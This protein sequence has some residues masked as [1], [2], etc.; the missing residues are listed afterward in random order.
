MKQKIIYIHRPGVYTKVARY[1]GWI[2]QVVD[3]ISTRV[4][5]ST[6]LTYIFLYHRKKGNGRNLSIS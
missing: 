3:I 2:Q 5:F 1:V 6:Q 4:Y